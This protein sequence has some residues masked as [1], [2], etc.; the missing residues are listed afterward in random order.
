MRKI[1]NFIILVLLTTLGISLNNEPSFSKKLVGGSLEEINLSKLDKIRE[2][3]TAESDFEVELSKEKFSTPSD[4]DNLLNQIETTF[5]LNENYYA[6]TSFNRNTYFKNLTD[7]SP[8][9][10]IGSCGYVSLIQTM[11]YY[12]TF[13]NDNV[14]PEQYDRTNEDAKSETEA[15]KQSPGVLRQ[16]YYSADYPTY[17][18]YCHA[19]KEY[20]LQSKLTLINNFINETD[21][22]NTYITE[23]GE[24]KSYFEYS[25]GAWSYQSM[26]NMFYGNS[27]T[28]KVN[29]YSNKTQSQYIR[30]IQETIDS[31]NPIIVHIQ[32]SNDNGPHSYHSVVAYAY[33][34]GGIYANF[35]W[36]EYANEYLLLG[37]EAGYTEI[38]Y[39]A[40][41]NYSNLGHTHSQNYVINNKKFCGCNL[42][43]E[44]FFETPEGSMDSDTFIYW[45]KNI[46]DP[47]ETYSISFKNSNTGTIL[48]RYTVKENEVK[49]SRN[50]WSSILSKCNGAL[51]ISL[52]RLSSKT[53]YNES[54]TIVRLLELTPE[55]YNFESQYFFY[56]KSQVVLSESYSIT[57]NR[58]RCGY[59]ENQYIILS[60]RRD[61]A[62]TAYLEYSF[63]TSVKRI[64]V[65]L[66]MWSANEFINAYNA[67]VFIQYKNKNNDWITV[68]DLMKNAVLSKDRNSPDK[69]SIVFP[70]GT[71]EFRFYSTSM[72]G[73]DRN[74]GR[75]CI[76]D[77]LIYFGG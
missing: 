33:D 23:D 42:N 77:M 31:G 65:D 60:A 62:H 10:N 53:K 4:Q 28:V 26:L 37:G 19:T 2:E 29:T 58:L 63:G 46:Y 44:A 40:T 15:K 34:E 59:I 8:K 32:K 6:S 75:I 3:Y 9:N 56:E 55:D 12:D 41:L 43:D 39:A 14:I 57:T 45:M 38:Y 48:A 16:T 27:T 22:D 54:V 7:F 17:Y 1:S 76:G 36:G 13:Y 69:Y 21:N 47:S 35:G 73:A 70:E 49:I 67:E 24:V 74:K 25:I 18:Q 11:S 52:K 5:S 30:L 20:D 68:L 72:Y 50:V 61:N 51:I 66:A 64:D 71:N